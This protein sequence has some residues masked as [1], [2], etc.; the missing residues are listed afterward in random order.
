MTAT[1]ETTGVRMPKTLGSG[2]GAG[3]ECIETGCEV[4][5]ILP[6]RMEPLILIW[7]SVIVLAV[8]LVDVLCFF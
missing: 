6:W 1:W 8:D 4:L 3:V 7:Y 5:F 2:T